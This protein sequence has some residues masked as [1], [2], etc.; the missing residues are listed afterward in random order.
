MNSNSIQNTLKKSGK[1]I[2]LLITAAAVSFTLASC[3]EEDASTSSGCEKALSDL[4]SIVQAKSAAF[5][6]NP[7]PST[8]SALRTATLNLIYKA[9][10]CGQTGIHNEQKAYWT[11]MDC[12][13]FA[14]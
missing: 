1:F 4:A 5:S 3:E 2:C 12:S 7:N 10:S 6:S 14:D 8:C 11:S 9:E 13:D